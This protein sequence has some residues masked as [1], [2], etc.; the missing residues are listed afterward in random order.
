MK[1][2]SRRKRRYYVQPGEAVTMEINPVGTTGL[3][4][5]VQNGVKLKNLGSNDAQKFKFTASTT[6][7]SLHFL[8]IEFSF[9]GAG[10]DTARYELV[11]SGSNG[12]SYSDFTAIAQSTPIKDPIFRF[13]VKEE[14]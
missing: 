10:T 13:T 5:A 11:L 7:N 12:G 8:V 9:A 6:E 3:V 2:V 1:R 4:T 14:Q